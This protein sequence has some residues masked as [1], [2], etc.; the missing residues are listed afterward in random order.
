MVGE[1]CEVLQRQAKIEVRDLDGWLTQDE[2]VS[3][4]AKGSGNEQARVIYVREAFGSRT[5]IVLMKMGAV[6]RIVNRGRVS[7]RQI[8]CPFRWH[9]LSVR[10]ANCLVRGNLATISHVIHDN[11]TL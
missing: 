7:V 3:A 8:S 4:I 6:R 1:I 10:C 9:E 2:I 5:V 11:I